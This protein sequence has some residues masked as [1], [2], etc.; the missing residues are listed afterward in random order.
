MHLYILRCVPAIIRSL[1]VAW[2]IIR[3]NSTDVY[4]YDTKKSVATDSESFFFSFSCG[5]FGMQRRVTRGGGNHYSSH[6]SA[7]TS[8]I[9]ISD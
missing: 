3:D 1:L 5:S 6:N 9:F 8:S 4:A 7:G 2:Y